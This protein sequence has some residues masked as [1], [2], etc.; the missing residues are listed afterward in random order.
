MNK[1]QVAA[2]ELIQSDARFLYTITDINQKANSISTNYIMMCQP[3]IG[4]FADGA[5]QWCKKVGLNAPCFNEREKAYYTALR[6]S[7]KLFEKTY[8]EFAAQSMEKLIES[9]RYFY[10]I[11]SLYEKIFGYYNVG[12]D[13]CNGEFCGNT[14]LCAVYIPMAIWGNLN[15][16]ITIRDISVIVGKLAAFFDC[17]T[18]PP[19]QYDDMNNVVRYKDYHFFENCP[20]V[21][22][23]ELGVVLF[24]ILCSI[25]YVT[26]FIENYFMEEIP[27]KFKFAYLQYY[28]LCNLINEINTTKGTKL[29]INNSLQNRGFRNCL[30]HYG[31]GQYM[32]EKDIM[33]SDILKG[34]TMKAFNMEYTVA[35]QRLFDFL[36]DLG[37]QIQ[38]SLLI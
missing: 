12:T 32:T 28:Y 2:Y 7:H 5:E 8:K 1:V 30:A 23:T 24:S 19:Y 9:D 34:L 3:Y 6:Q 18:Y 20:F 38:N 36:K 4:I 14:L 26:V 29:F 21:E 33:D 11:R 35:K 25:N 16:G 17:K 37:N 27:Q 15:A 10:S 22:K 13:L 31:L